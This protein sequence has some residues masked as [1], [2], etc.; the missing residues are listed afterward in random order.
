MNWTKTIWVRYK[1][2]FYFK[3]L[4]FKP[5]SVRMPLDDT[6]VQELG[7]KVIISG[8]GQNRVNK[9]LLFYLQQFWN[10]RMH[11][12]FNILFNFTLHTWC[13]RVWWLILKKKLRKER[14]SVVTLRASSW[15]LKHKIWTNGTIFRPFK[16]T[17]I[18][19][20]LDKANE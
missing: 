16:C 17:A 20:C 18:K 11:S 15:V 13:I 2:N 14:E 4:S 8:V 1:T 7:W 12:Q 9:P 3:T 6:I 10:L 5:H 19:F